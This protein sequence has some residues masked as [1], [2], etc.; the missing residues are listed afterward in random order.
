MKRRAL[1]MATLACTLFAADPGERWW[2]HVLY[3]ADDGLEGR[4]T[5]SEGHRKA[6]AYVASEFEKAGLEPAGINAYIQPVKFHA[7]RI[8]EAGCKLDLV[9]SGKTETL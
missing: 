5:G 1:W 3:L 9:R 6:A 7:R 2:R 4:L 8:L